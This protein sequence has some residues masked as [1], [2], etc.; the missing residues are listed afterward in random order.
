ML[1]ICNMKRQGSRVD[2]EQ[3]AA[4]ACSAQTPCSNGQLEVPV[5]APAG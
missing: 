5:V 4:A 2:R 1:N 3:C